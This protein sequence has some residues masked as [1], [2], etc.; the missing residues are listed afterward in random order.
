VCY[1]IAIHSS[2]VRDWALVKFVKAFWLII[3]IFTGETRRRVFCLRQITGVGQGLDWQGPAR[4]H[5]SGFGLF[6][7]TRVGWARGTVGSF[8]HV[9]SLLSFYSVERFYLAYVWAEA[10]ILRDSVTGILAV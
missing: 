4:V 8:F 9:Q 1:G 2:I 7:E 6:R 3:E 10:V 5:I